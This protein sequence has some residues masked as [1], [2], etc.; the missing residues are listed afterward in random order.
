MKQ[1]K[2]L[3]IKC[4]FREIIIYTFLINSSFISPSILADNNKSLINSKNFRDVYFKNDINHEDK[5]SSE[6]R[7]N[8]FF[9][10]DYSL[11]NKRFSDLVLPFTSR[12]LRKIYEDKLKQM[13]IKETRKSNDVFFKDK[14]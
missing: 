3:K 7:F 1:K 12:D 8:S 5:D 10:I 9:G 13:S 14:L 11:E 6:I 4:L 2:Y